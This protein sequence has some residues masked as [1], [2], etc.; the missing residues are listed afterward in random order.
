[1]QALVCPYCQTEFDSEP[2]SARA[3]ATGVVDCPACERSFVAPEPDSPAGPA[4]AP[5]DGPDPARPTPARRRGVRPGGATEAPLAVTALLG[6]AGAALFYLAVVTPLSGT[7]FAA[8]FAE[9]GWVPYA[10]TFLTAWSGA[11]LVWKGVLLRRQSRALDFDLLPAQIAPEVTPGN[12]HVFA[13]YVRNLPGAR[14]GHFLIERVERALR[15]F[16]AR[17]SVREVVEQVRTQAEADA[18]RVDASYAMLR[19][20]IW[21]VPILGFIGTVMGIGEAVGGFSAAVGAAADLSTLKGSIGAVTSG[22]GVA[23]D[24]TLLALVMSLLIMFPTSSLKRAEEHFLAAV[25]E[26]VDEHLVRRLADGGGDAGDAGGRFA[27]REL[28]TLERL[29]GAVEELER[30]LDRQEAGG[31]ARPVRSAGS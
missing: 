15:H 20:F 26:Y 30:R 11:M 22:L 8:L 31:P 25:E 10:I 23:F 24:T 14:R 21:A 29:A 18:E 6:A 9:R 28:E 17:P 2:E 5:G 12:A 27:A 13:S 1:M 3:A 19:V 7:S 16:R 4:P